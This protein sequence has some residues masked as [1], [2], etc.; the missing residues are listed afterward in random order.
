MDSS[1]RQWESSELF[2]LP[3]DLGTPR[4]T[5]ISPAQPQ[6]PLSC[7]TFRHKMETLPRVPIKI[8]ICDIYAKIRATKKGKKKASTRLFDSVGEDRTKA[9]KILWMS[10]TSVTQTNMSGVYVGRTGV[11][12]KTDRMCMCVC[13]CGSG[14]V[15]LWRNRACCR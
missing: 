3:V 7:L 8:S 1:E 2:M 14:S 6:Q 10:Y 5:P 9:A 12:G 11:H 4:H 15:L 13:V